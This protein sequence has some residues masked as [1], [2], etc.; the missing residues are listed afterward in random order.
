MTFLTD[1]VHNQFTELWKIHFIFYSFLTDIPFT[2]FLEWLI[3]SC[4]VVRTKPLRLFL[5]YSTIK[6]FDLSHLLMKK[7]RENKGR[8]YFLYI[9]LYTTSEIPL[10]LIKLPVTDEIKVKYKQIN[11]FLFMIKLPTWLKLNVL[12]T[13]SFFQF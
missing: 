3:N 5:V 10:H 2:N 11:K 9:H 7:K 6:H 1:V 4:R 8:S 13:S 12:N